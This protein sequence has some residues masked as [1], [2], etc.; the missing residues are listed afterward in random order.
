MNRFELGLPAPFRSADVLRFLGRD[1]LE[2]S[3]R[4]TDHGFEKAFPLEGRAALVRVDFL[5]GSARCE[6]D[7]PESNAE[8]IVRRMLGLHTPAKQ[9]EELHA[10][11]PLLGRLIRNQAG[12]RIPQTAT[13][14]EGLAWAITGQQINLRFATQLMR[15]ITL[16]FG[17]PH[18]CG[19]RAYPTPEHLSHLKI[20]DLQP[21]KFSRSKADYLLGA[22]RAVVQ[23]ALQTIWN[24]TSYTETERTLG[25]VRGIGP[26]TVQYVM[27]RALGFPDC[28]PASDAGL[29][30]A[31]HRLPEFGR[32]PDP[33]EIRALLSRFAPYRSLAVCHL[34]ASL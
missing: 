14:W 16:E 12:L 31:L 3:S 27:L 33:E 34:W 24:A 19:L 8:A 26:W 7:A 9:F 4:V 15:A 29:A 30:Q 13:P 11:D 10:Q 23:G 20:E 21:L 5:Q 32:R 22:A 6:S 1:P 18:P 2:T 28:L 25:G 17:L